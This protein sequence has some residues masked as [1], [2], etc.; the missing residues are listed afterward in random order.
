MGSIVRRATNQ[1]WVDNLPASAVGVT[2]AVGAPVKLDML[3]QLAIDYAAQAKGATIM[4][5]R[6]S[7]EAI[8]TA[9]AGTTPQGSLTAGFLVEGVT[10]PVADLDPT[11]VAGRQR[12]WMWQTDWYYLFNTSA[13]ATATP[14]QMQESR[15][16]VAVKSKRIIPGNVETLFLVLGASGIGSTAAWRVRYHLRTLVRVP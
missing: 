8:Q 10:M 2:V 9:P 1:Y 6:G 11:T 5:V 14:T 7:I 15:R 4:G 13:E 12:S 16:E 3:P